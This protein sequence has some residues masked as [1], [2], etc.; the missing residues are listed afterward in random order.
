MNGKDELGNP[1]E[2]QATA[3]RARFTETCEMRATGRTAS[4]ILSFA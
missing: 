4:G 3:G 2:G 1:I